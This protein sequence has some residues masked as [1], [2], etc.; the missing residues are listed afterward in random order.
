MRTL[1]L[2]YDAA[3]A[4]ARE[5]RRQIMPNSG[6]ERQLRLWEECQYDVYIRNLDDPF[7]SKIEKASYRAWK[8]E[9]D[10]VFS[11]RFAGNTYSIGIM[12]EKGD[13]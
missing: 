3:L 11:K 4:M 5:S 2:S 12:R 9:R 1:N 8:E 13:S 7:S 6:F 10:D